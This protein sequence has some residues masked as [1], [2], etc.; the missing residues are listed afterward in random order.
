MRDAFKTVVM[1]AVM[2]GAFA[3]VVVGCR[4]VGFRA[5]GEGPGYEVDVQLNEAELDIPVDTAIFEGE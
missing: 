5:K 4:L 3:L 2:A 1:V